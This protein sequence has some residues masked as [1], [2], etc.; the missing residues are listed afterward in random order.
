M[1]GV[2]K[3]H[4]IGRLGKDPETRTLENGSIVTSFSVATSE[5]YKDKNGAKQETTDW[6]NMT[7]WGKLADLA[8]KFLKKGDLAYFE[9][10]LR[11]RSWEKDGITRYTT[12]ILVNQ[13]TMLGSK[14]D[15]PAQQ[16]A[17]GS[18][19]DLPF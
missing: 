17:E 13:M 8:A 14:N 6:H 7:I 19:D 15:Q 3:V 1:S 11:T 5:T 10:K 2:N 9:G 18:D 12:E 16:Q 4:I